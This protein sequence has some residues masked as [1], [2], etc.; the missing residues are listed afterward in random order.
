MANTRANVLTKKKCTAVSFVNVLCYV[1]LS[2][3]LNLILMQTLT[4]F[5]LFH[6]TYSFAPIITTMATRRHLPTKHNYGS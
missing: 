5:I 6:L 1:D 3:H 2:I 4:L